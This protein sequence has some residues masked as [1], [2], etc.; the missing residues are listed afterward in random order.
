MSSAAG[1]NELCTVL[2]LTMLWTC[3]EPQSCPPPCLCSGRPFPNPDQNVSCQNL[4]L[5]T[6]PDRLPNT[7]RILRLGGNSIKTITSDRLS[8]LQDLRTLDLSANLI[9]DIAENAFAGLVSL[10]T[11]DLTA[12]KLEFISSSM[13]EGLGNLQNLSLRR[14]PI[15]CLRKFTFSAIPSLR[16]LDLGEL[17][18]LRA[19]SKRTF[20][21]IP[22]VVNLNMARSNLIVVPYMN[23]LNNTAELDLSRNN[24][25]AVSSVDFQGLFQLSKLVLS[26]N[27]ISRIER[28]SFD[29]LPLLSDLDLSNNSLNMLP[30]GL[31]ANMVSVVKI[32]LREN[33]WSCTCE[34]TWL[35]QWLKDNMNDNVRT[36]CGK[37]RSPAAWRNTPMCEVP[38]EGLKCSP[39][40]ITDTQG[41]V[42]VTE[43]DSAALLCRTTRDAGINWITPNGT[44]INKR[45]AFKVRI[46][47]TPEGNLNITNVTKSDEGVYRCIAKNT[48]GISEIDTVLKVPGRLPVSVAA[49]T[50]MP[51]I[52][53]L[54]EDQFDSAICA[55]ST[56]LN[57]RSTPTSIPVPTV[58]VRSGPKFVPPT[59]DVFRAQPGSG[60]D[61]AS[62]V[63]HKMYII[64]SISAVVTIGIVIWVTVIVTKKCSKW[65]RKRKM[66][67]KKRMDR[68]Q[69]DCPSTPTCL[70]SIEQDEPI[71]LPD[72]Y[73]ICNGGSFY[74]KGVM[75]FPTEETIV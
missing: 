15:V 40:R 60:K 73:N 38:L 6:I 26:S 57:D 13:F 69:V 19:I 12:N 58:R 72:V 23:Y 54:L 41:L 46:K 75:A 45:G 1:C 71:E 63:D 17:T 74:T 39:P 11:L 65:K 64:A 30:Y 48:A 10:H 35:S 3:I 33:P 4:D 25:T 66:M 32:D 43:G 51:V 55:V 61:G 7:A 56:T 52:E 20:Y 62:T 44:N 68:G 18:K 49:A 2:V 22:H 27:K 31:F 70:K 50:E 36:L 53:E 29:D 37:C 16:F 47:L 59:D 14:N 42:N 34:A 21:G 8:E 9:S 28:N 5:I 67:R 24:I